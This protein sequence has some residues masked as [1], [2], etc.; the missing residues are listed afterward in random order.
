MFQIVE[1][2]ALPLFVLMLNCDE[3][4]EQ[5]C[6][7]TALW[8]LS[9]ERTSRDRIQKEPGCI[10][11]LQNLQKSDNETASYEAN[12]ALFIIEK[13]S[14]RNGKA[15]FVIHWRYCKRLFI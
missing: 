6:A 8:N 14:G 9:F 3:I 15:D 2:G 7:A 11:A 5:I 10:E 12:G 1:A 4:D 13:N